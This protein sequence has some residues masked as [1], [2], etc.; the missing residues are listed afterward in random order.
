MDEEPGFV[1]ACSQAQQ[2]AW[3]RDAYPDLWA[4]LRAKVATGQFVPVGGMWVEADTTMPG[5][6]AMVRQ[7]V[8]GKAFLRDELGVEPEEVWLPDSFGY[9]AAMP[10]IARLAGCRWF[11]TQK[12]SWNRTN[13]MPHHTFRWEGIDGTQIFTHFPPVDT[14]NSDLSAAELAHASAG[15]AEH[16]RAGTSLVPFGW[17]NGGGGPTREM[18]A[19]AARTA[20]LEGSPRVRL[21]SP[22]EF[23][24]G[25][26]A[27][28]PDAPVW[29]GEMYLEAHR[30][31]LTSQARTKRGNRRSE[32]LLRHA[33]LWSTQAALAGLVVYPHDVLDRAW[34]TVLFNQF[35]DIL[36]G[37]SIAWVHRDAE[38]DHAGVAARLE[39]VIG[40]AVAALAG[41]GH[42]TIA[43]NAAPVAQG[44]VPALGA[45]PVPVGVPGAGVVVAAA[46]DGWTIDNGALRVAVDARGLLTS[47]W[48][49]GAGRELIAPGAVGNLLQLHRDVPNRW[50]AWDIDDHYRR[51]RT[52]LDAADAVAVVAGGLRITRCFG[53]SRVEQTVTLPAPDGDVVAGRRV[54]VDTTIDWHERQKLLKVAFA[55]DVHAE[56]FASETQFGHVWRP[57]HTNTSWDEARF[58]VCAHRWVHVDEQ[59]Y[60][61]GIANDSTYG[62][63]VT[64]TARPAGGTTTTVR[65]SLLR[66]PTYPDPDADQGH[67]RLRYSLVAGDRPATIAVGY[68]LNLPLRHVEGATG[69]AP[70]LTVDHPAVIVEAVKLAE[71]R[72]GD[73]VVRLYEA[74]GGRARARVGVDAGRAVVAATE[75]DLLERPAADG[76][77]DRPAA[78]ARAAALVAWDAVGFSVTLRPFQI[79]TVRLALRGRS[80]QPAVGTGP[81]PSTRSA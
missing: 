71:D 55:L 49:V 5:G 48:D 80:V 31:T 58:E 24:E 67:H 77:P 56:R 51:V 79:V 64:R 36:P 70:L 66:A 52:D 42:T 9:S 75:T 29:R 57:T 37:S 81:P 50:D 61:V 59:G 69:I 44:A 34:K 43:V 72:S 54:D 53:T 12:M 11:L 32:H 47:V 39:E 4:R 16:G 17:G 76:T 20:D 60:G 63:D 68:A 15:F 14:Y 74:H 19:A 6:E 33:E 78:L 8:T 38:H 45:A 22:R 35:H 27:E 21:G 62:H 30:G 73:L 65:L 3:V 41:A 25:A 18:L 13:R 28:Y 46:G 40:T 26:E 2:L 7:F 1:F 10:Q 23:F